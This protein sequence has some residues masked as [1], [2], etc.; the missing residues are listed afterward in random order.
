MT[1]YKALAV[2]TISLSLAACS[3]ESPLKTHP[4]KETV[5][6]LMNASANAERRLH[7]PIKSIDYG[8]RNRI[9][10]EVMFHCKCIV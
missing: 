3:H 1:F 8:Y 7:F 6:F 4:A 2:L 9:L 5:R 10:F